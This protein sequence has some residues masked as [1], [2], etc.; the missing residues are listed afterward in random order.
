MT[1]DLGQ[2]ISVRPLAVSHTPRSHNIKTLLGKFIT[3]TLNV[4]Y[5]FE[6]IPMVMKE[7][8]DA[9]IKEVARIDEGAKVQVICDDSNNTEE[10]MN[11][12]Q[13]NF[14]VYVELGGL[15]YLF[16]YEIE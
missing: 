7:I 9:I 14:D 15:L 3:E 5:K 10:T 13:L 11:A 8:P 4:K 6:L 12:G 2:S 16:K 1:I